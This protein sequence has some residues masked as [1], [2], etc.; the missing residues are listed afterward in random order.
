MSDTYGEHEHF[1]GI[2]INRT[3]SYFC[4][5]LGLDVL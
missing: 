3:H 5:L 1:K 2:A 4:L